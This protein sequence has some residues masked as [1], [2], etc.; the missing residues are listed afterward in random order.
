MHVY[1]D[2][3]DEVLVIA[4]AADEGIVQTGVGY[5]EEELPLGGQSHAGLD[6]E[7]G[8]A[9]PL[10]PELDQQDPLYILKGEAG[11]VVLTE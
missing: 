4:Q 9:A 11:I 3:C 10:D 6:Y 7:L 1:F 8:D 5:V 2:P